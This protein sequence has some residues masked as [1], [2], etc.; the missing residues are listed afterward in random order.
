[1]SRPSVKLP[2]A[3]GAQMRAPTGRRSIRLSDYDYSSAGPYF[4]TTCTHNRKPVFASKRL[5][6]VVWQAWNWLPSRFPGV[7]LDEFII[8]PDHVHFVVWLG[9]PA[10][11][12]G[13]HPAAQ[14]LK[15]RPP[16]LG[17]VVGAFKTVAARSI[18]A[19]RGTIGRSVWQRNYYEHIVRH[20]AELARVREYIQDN[21]MQEHTHQSGDM[22][23]AWSP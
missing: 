21:P 6:Q 1:M 18:N 9:D 2:L 15:A 10:D 3:Q 23:E 17:N 13:S 14:R 16:T 22:S 19:S 4:V 12:R 8:M 5:A 11:R 20:E 7:T